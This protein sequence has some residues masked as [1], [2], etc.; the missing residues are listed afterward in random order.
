MA[1]VGFSTGCFYRAGLSVEQAVDFYKGLG[2]G[3]VELSFATLKEL[4][5]AKEGILE[6]GDI[7]KKFK[8]VTFHAPFRKI[9]YYSSVD[10][11]TSE[12]VRTFKGFCRRIPNFGVVV[13]PDKVRDFDRLR[14][15]GVDF[16]IE[17]MDPRKEYGTLPEHFEELKKYGF[18]YVLDLHHAHQVDPSMGVARQLREVMGDNLVEFHVSGSSADGKHVP[19]HSARNRK[20]IEKILKKN[21][22]VPIILEGEMDKEETARRELEYV[23]GI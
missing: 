16:L 14:D 13:H 15:S 4:R 3:G 17:N 6:M 22:D 10:V 8:R 18:S 20:D 19:L 7:L 23:R 12:V 1:I 11:N 21:P 2:A 5:D 9:S